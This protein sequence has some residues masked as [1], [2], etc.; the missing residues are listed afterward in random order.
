MPGLTFTNNGNQWILCL[1]G[2]VSALNA[3]VE[4]PGKGSWSADLLANSIHLHIAGQPDVS[5]PVKYS[6]NKNN[7]LVVVVPGG[8]AAPADSTPYTFQGHIDVSDNT[9]VRYTLFG[10]DL[11][12]AVDQAGRPI[13]LFVHGALSINDSLDQLVVTLPDKST[14]FI[15]G[16]EPDGGSVLPSQNVTGTGGS[17]RLSFFAVTKN[18]DSSGIPHKMTA[19]ILF[20]G[21]W[22]LNQDG[23]AFKASGTSGKEL[24]I[25]LGGTFKG[26]AAGISV[27][28]VGND[29]DVAFNIHGKHRYNSPGGQNTDVNWS[30][31]LGYS[32][33]QFAAVVALGASS[34]PA[35]TGGASFQMSGTLQ[36]VGGPTNSLALDLKATYNPS[37]DGQLIFTADVSDGP[38]GVSYA[39]DLE[40]KYTVKGGL[41]TF[42]VIL[43][44]GAGGNSLKVEL[45]YTSTDG[46]LKAHMDAVMKGNQVSFD[47]E[48]SVHLVNGKMVPA[49]PPVA[50][51]T[52][53]SS[54]AKSSST[55]TA[56]AAPVSGV[57]GSK[58][59]GNPK[60]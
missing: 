57:A 58:P 24:S 31:G 50:L 20:L 59:L 45:G 47:F 41:V 51:S 18:T 52:A 5:V 55:A 6:F 2:T 17:D 10:A 32:E 12:A 60:A 43:D 19:N 46:N 34:T 35:N 37:P 16:S 42:D 21:S 22:D 53:S 49:G 15:T 33:K 14:T 1:D 7:Q 3:G 23:I 26:V 13:V 4:Q 29:T 48:L 27:H 28:Q 54:S 56:G 30:V 36:F 38:G 40:G 39:L 44:G 25:Q 8:G 9:V 11:K